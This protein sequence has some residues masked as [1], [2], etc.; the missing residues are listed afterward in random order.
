MP[1]MDQDVY[2]HFVPKPPAQEVEGRILSVLGGV[3]QIGQYQVVSINRGAREGIEVGN[4]LR[5]FQSGAVVEDMV[6]PRSKEKVQLPEEDAGVMLVF[7][8]FDKVSYGL[9]MKAT[10]PLHVLDIVRNP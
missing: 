9:V 2:T 10:R 1:I 6:N 7:R 5:I 8:I 3:T 4:V